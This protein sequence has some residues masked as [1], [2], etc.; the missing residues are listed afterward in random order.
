MNVSDLSRFPQTAAGKK[1]EVLGIGVSNLP[2]VDFLLQC[3]VLVTVRDRK[4]EEQLGNL[5][6]DLKAKGVS[7]I[8]GEHYLNDLEGDYIF[9][10]P[11]I[12]PD[13]PEILMGVAK[14]ALLT[15]EMELFFAL[16]KAKT[17]AVTGSDGKTTTTTLVSLLLKEA[18]H[19]VYV[20]GNIGSPLL[21]LVNEMTEEDFAV[22]ELSSFQLMTL[23]QSA[24]IAAVTNLS[25]N[26]L[27]WHRSMEE[28]IEA[29][30]NIFVHKENRILV[31]NADNPPSRPLAQQAP[32]EI[33]LFSSEKELPS[34]MY[35]LE[36]NIYLDGQ[37]I[38]KNEEI[39]LPGRHNRQN[40]MT[41][42]SMVRDFVP[43]E[44]LRRVAE[45]FRGVEHR[46][47]FVRE[48]RGVKIYNSSIDSSPSRT[49]AALSCFGE[50]VNVIC[51]GYDK[52][53]PFA[54]LAEA[55][56]QKAR[57]V[58]LTGAT[59][60]A[61]EQALLECS[62]SDKPVILREPDFTKAVLKALEACRPGEVLLLSPGCASFDAFPNFMV[63]G[64]TFKKLI[65]D[66]K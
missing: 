56:C 24:E 7:L 33:R 51:G 42:Y 36:G 26:H 8:T 29:K 39:L 23:R 11:G 22:L 63:R 1:A 30:T 9:R 28:Y 13:L 6:K 48:Y 44:A 35:E 52:H 3:G 12:R 31:L 27:D 16:C 62:L 40:Y 34:G 57:T 15:S 59:A 37:Q 38:L 66:L 54:P 61:I 32:G 10:S 49:A 45:S 21:P 2:L 17:L 20:G 43:V 55:L 18:G 65:N 58:T 64:N 50:K 41:A 53:I 60:Q 4:S 5:P 46:L 47:E 14:G 19:R 25:P